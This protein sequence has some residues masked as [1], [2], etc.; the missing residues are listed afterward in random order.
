MDILST[1]F[2]LQTRKIGLMVPDVVTLETHT[3]ELVVTEHPVERQSP[4]GTGY[5]VDNAYRKPSQLVMS[6][7]FA[8]GGS[9]LDLLDTRSIGMGY[10]SSPQEVYAAF[11]NMQQNRELLNVTTGKRQYSNMVLQKIVVTTKAD[12][13][14]V[15]SADLTLSE[16]IVTS[17]KAI[18]VAA[19]ANMQQG[20]NTSVTSNTGT[21]TTVPKSNVSL[22][23]LTGVGA[24]Q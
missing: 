13:E 11:L 4:V 1:L 20:A 18:K 14:H 17:T 7:G 10:G 5:I 15:L 12:S 23:R 2:H 19:K 8:S 16:V 3:D 6:V 21:K 22:S 24:T 9:F